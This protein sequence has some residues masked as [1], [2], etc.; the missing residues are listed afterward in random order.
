M[1]A[2]WFRVALAASVALLGAA[3]SDDDAAD[4]PTVAVT[5]QNAITDPEAAS[6]TSPPTTAASA[7]TIAPS[8]PTTPPPTTIDQ[9]AVTNAAVIAAAVQS[10]QDYLY[11]VRNYDAADA[12]DVLGHTTVRDSPSWALI[13]S[14]ID[15]LRTHGWRS[16]ENPAVPSTLTVEGDV[17][18][19]DGPTGM[20]AQLTVC[21]IDSGVVF[22]P[23]G[24]P[25]GSDAIVNDQI[26]AI[27]DRIT[28]VRDEGGAWKLYEG[29]GMGSWPGATSCPA[30]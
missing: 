4:P 12:L 1:P 20:R 29:A 7:T 10:R 9:V 6:T 24:A 11:A 25:D 8:Q 23:G 14:N 16:R 5:A 18:L 26:T 19:P 22:E 28:M 27:R 13:T 30:D 21:T 2:G 3:C 15:T 17:T